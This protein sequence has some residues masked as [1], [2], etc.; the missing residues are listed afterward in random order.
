MH[1]NAPVLLLQLKT[2]SGEGAWPPPQTHPLVS[3]QFAPS[4]QY[5]WIRRM[6]ELEPCPGFLVIRGGKNLNLFLFCFLA[7]GFYSLM[8][9]LVF[10]IGLE[11]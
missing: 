3:A 4:S 1:K 6:A 2:F 5:L 9:F 11:S 7:Y 8:G 10:H